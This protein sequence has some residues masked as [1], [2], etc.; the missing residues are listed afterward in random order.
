MGG[1]ESPNLLAEFMRYYPDVTISLQLTNRAVDLAEEGID[2]ELRSGPIE[3]AN[4]IVR[5]LLLMNMVVCAS[6]VYWKKH[7]KP[8]IRATCRATTRSR[9]RRGASSP[10]G[11]STTTARRSTYR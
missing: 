3:D 10:R 11:A 2:V 7:G 6:P 9:S 8:S 5:K 4:L 1:G